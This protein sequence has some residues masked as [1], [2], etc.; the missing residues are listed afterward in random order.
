M[1]LGDARNL[2]PWNPWQEFQEVEKEADRLFDAAL[3]RLRHALPGREIA[4]VPVVDI[5]ESA[6]EYRFYLSLPGVVEEDIDISVEGQ[7]L[8]IRGEREAPY[9][10]QQVD[11]H[12]RRWKYGYFERRVEMPF[13]LESDAISASYDAG[14]LTVKVAKSQ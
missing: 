8:I 11:S 12:L 10:V 2:E 9:D 6:E 4:F 5:V 14:V 3:A 13:K 7:V 1:P